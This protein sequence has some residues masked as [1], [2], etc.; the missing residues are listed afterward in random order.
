MTCLTS[1]MSKGVP[2]EFEAAQEEAYVTFTCIPEVEDFNDGPDDAPEPTIT[3]L[4][5]RHL[6]SGS[7]TTG[8]RTW[9]ASL[10]LGTYFLTQA[11]SQLV[12][13]KNILELGTGT[14]FLSIILAKCLHANHVT[15]TDGD[16]GVTEALNENLTLNGLEDQHK[17][18]TETLIWGHDLGGTWVE[19]DCNAHPYDVIIGADIVR[20][21][22]EVLF[23]GLYTYSAHRH[24][25][26]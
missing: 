12:R 13:D 16:K 10:H 6:I 15:V 17:V 21:F 24:T 9:E 7:Q 1:F 2:S 19:E 14:G 25:T 23:L 11:G 26:R 8:F 18:R 4:E 20:L 22:H 3:L 5:R